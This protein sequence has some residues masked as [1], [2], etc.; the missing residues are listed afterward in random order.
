MISKSIKFPHQP[1]ALLIA[2]ALASLSFSATSAEKSANTQTDDTITVSANAP[3]ESAWG[4]V[5]SYVAKQ[6]ATGTKTDT[7]LVKTPQSIS[8]VTREQMD[9]LQPASVKDAFSYTPGVMVDN[10]GSSNAYDSVNIR[11]FSQIGTN[12]YLDGLTLPGDNYSNFQIDPYLLERA[13][14]M[15][16]PVSVLYGKSDPGGIISLVSKRPTTETIHEVQFKTG[17]DGFYQTGFDFGGDVNND[18]RYTYRLTG[19]ARD[20]N[21]MQT[22]ESSK[23]YA[24]APAFTW[25]PDDKTT[26][27]FLSDF[28]NQPDTGYYGWLPEQGT[29]RD[30]A[31]GK[32][33]RHFNDG[34][35]GFNKLSRKQ[36]LVGYAFSHTFDDVWTVRQNLHYGTIGTDYRSIY[37]AGVSA[38]DPTQLSRGVMNDREHLSTFAVDTQL[39]AKYDTGTVAHTTLLGIDYQHLRNDIKYQ[40]GSASNLSLINPQYGNQNVTYTGSASLLDRQE[41][42]GLYAQDQAQW[43]K[44]MFTLGGRY[45]WATT[46]STNRL[47]DNSVSKQKDGEFTWRGGVNYLFDSGFAPYASYSESFEPTS[48][49]DF[50]GNTFQASRAKQYETGIKYAPNNALISGSIAVYQLT[51]DKNLSTDPDHTLFSV[52]T[53]EIRSRGLEFETKAAVNENINL[54]ASFTYTDAK[55]TKDESYKGNRPYEIPKYMASLWSDYTFYE[56]ALSGLTLGAGVRY[57]GT[58]YGDD[59][60]TFKV[61]PY[62]I[63]DA[64]IKYD[65][66]RF[67]MPGSSLAVNVNNLFDKKYVSSCYATYACYWGAE[68]QVTATATFSF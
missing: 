6:S 41:Q 17:T 35:P 49:S 55:Y 29:V 60:N 44:W 46:E 13:E 33:S 15:R 56:T 57:V 24:I 48:G 23:S 8:V 11:G 5:G 18:D 14:L 53:G 43:N 34:E 3:Q 16:G 42:T 4:P 63:W 45:D 59:A 68:R 51:K 38:T 22:G 62:T 40:S 7:P 1:L 21:Q 30:G 61:D 58:S 9:L 28:Q 52:Q 31:G 37:G 26:F 2:S 19:V 50:S 65:L 47:N 67:G 27:T 10:R 39:Q 20:T 66:G 32:L 25:H 36:K 64:A 54:L 12:I